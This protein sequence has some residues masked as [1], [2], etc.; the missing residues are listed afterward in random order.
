M[1]VR[2]LLL[3]A[4]FIVPLVFADTQFPY[5][6][7]TVGIICDSGITD[8]ACTSANP[9]TYTIIPNESFVVN[10]TIGVY[11]SHTS[12]TAHVEVTFSYNDSTSAVLNYSTNSLTAVTY[13]VENPN[14]G[15]LVDR[16]AWRTYRSGTTN[17]LPYLSVSDFWTRTPTINLTLSLVNPVNGSSIAGFCAMFTTASNLTCGVT[18]GSSIVSLSAGGWNNENR[19]INYAR[20]LNSQEASGNVTRYATINGQYCVVHPWFSQSNFCT[21]AYFNTGCGLAGPS[22]QYYCLVTDELSQRCLSVSMSDNSSKENEALGC[23]NTIVALNGSSDG[24]GTLTE[25]TARF[26]NR[27][28]TPIIDKSF[29][30][31]SASDAD[32]RLII[33]LFNTYNNP[34]FSNT[35]LKSDARTRARQ[36]C[37][38]MVRYNYVQTNKISLVNSS[39]NITYWP[40]GG[41]DVAASGISGADFM[42]SG[43]YGD[44]VLALLACGVDTG[45][46]SYYTIA[47]DVAE[48]LF[49]AANWT[50]DRDFRAPP[51]RAFNWTTG[52][53]P[54]AECTTICSPDYIDDPDGKRMAK[55][56]GA[57]RLYRDA[58]RTLHPWASTYCAKWYERINTTHYAKEWYANGT[59]K[60]N[61]VDDYDANALATYIDMSQ[62]ASNIGNRL[63][64]TGQKFVT[65]TNSFDSAACQ[66]LY[67]PSFPIEVLGYLTST[68][69]ITTFG[70]TGVNSCTG[71][72]AEQTYTKGGF[73][74]TLTSPV[75]NSNLSGTSATINFTVQNNNASSSPSPGTLPQVL[76]NYTFCTDPAAQGFT[77]GSGWS[78]DS[79]NCLITY[80]GS[81]YGGNLVT[82]N[83]GL[84][85]YTN[86]YN[87]S[88]TTATGNISLFKLHY[89][90]GAS[91]LDNAKYN[92]ERENT[93][94]QHLKYDGGSFSQTDNYAFGSNITHNI[95]VNVSQNVTRACRVS[96]SCTSVELQAVSTL[97]NY[98]AIQSADTLSGTQRFNL[99][100]LIVYNTGTAYNTSTGLNSSMNVS[101]YSSD[102]TLLKQVNTTANGSTISYDWTGISGVKRWYVNVW[103]VNGRQDFGNFTFSLNSAGANVTY[104][105]TGTTITHNVSGSYNISV[106]NVTGGHSV[107]TYFNVTRSLYSINSSGGS[108]WSTL[109]MNTSQAR[110]ILQAYRL[111]LNTSIATF[112]ATNGIGV[113]TTSASQLTIPANNG[114]NNI[115][116]DVPGNYSLNLTCTVTTPLSTPYCN[117]TGVYDALITVG[118]NYDGSGVRNFTL[119]V[120]NATLGGI[121]Y[122]NYT[123]NGVLQ[124]PALQ[125]YTY[126]YD[127]Y[128]LTSYSNTNYTRSTT[129]NSDYYNFSVFISNVFYLTIKN[130]TSN[131]IIT[132]QT[133][134]VQILS[135]ARNENFSTNNG[136]LFVDFLVPGNYTIRYWMT[137]AV[138]RDYYV[139]FTGQSTN[140]ITLYVLDEGISQFYLPKVYNQ[141]GYACA[142]NTVS[143][144][145]YFILGDNTGEYKVVE[146]AKTDS[147]GQAVLRVVPN[148]IN[149]KLAFSGSCGSFVS[150]P[151]KFT[152][153]TNSFTVSSGSTALSSIAGMQ[154]V[155]RSL[156]FNNATNTFVC[157]WVDASNIVTSGTLK[158]TK[159]YRSSVNTSYFLT[160][161]ETPIGS[162]AHTVTD[163]NDTV[164]TA[165]CYLHTNTQFS[166]Y[167][168]TLVKSFLQ[169]FRNF[170]MIGIFLSLLVFLVVV[171]MGGGRVEFIF[172]GAIGSLFMMGLFGFMFYTWTAAVGLLIIGAIVAYKS[173]T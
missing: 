42:Y 14:P 38:D 20:L 44:N 22:F 151:Q 145:R 117:A 92:F 144:M 96:G 148:T 28:G 141:N 170:G 11:T 66:G 103:S 165:T 73:S 171:F 61:L 84:S 172:A 49:A 167:P 97:A 88:I 118:A 68:A 70:A 79:T 7:S 108:Y 119:N 152:A 37:L 168:D 17:G 107:P 143:L 31:D 32:Q 4:L 115:M 60:S 9:I 155:S 129:N 74:L 24:F 81:D 54:R 121:L 62:N 160:T 45:N 86:G 137:E 50:P 149:Y 82:P 34:F 104:C 161:D 48:N 27:T 163:T 40:A 123:T 166:I 43:Y 100:Q 65:G 157:T 47:E 113:N 19:S 69:S 53:T 30:D 136:T 35:T 52:S 120:S 112:N 89:M 122:H 1:K 16:I 23:Y 8:P 57:E 46:T 63:N 6:Q 132:N 114:T 83:L 98:I 126:K 169:G 99:T 173:R 59:R 127:L 51:G 102:G 56:C 146:M 76:A 94:H 138:Q 131:S 105:T 142:Q 80:N 25:W 90:T 13:V 162:I 33:S 87:I 124:I 5:A 58:G 116:V 55:F 10:T 154:S 71:I 77:L 156:I 78:W 95:Y 15:K 21:S 41:S 39:R 153:T 72:G 29:R 109:I 164:Y 106:F 64:L 125:G 75:N 101:V 158:I 140:N 147:I 111:L 12:T 85:S 130:E 36:M 26:D 93:T 139:I 150:A 135:E 18:S 67:N 134:Y 128:N 2:F 133:V 159:Q 110:I 91:S 3:I